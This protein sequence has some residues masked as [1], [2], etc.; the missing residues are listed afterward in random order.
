VEDKPP[1]SIGE[2]RKTSTGL[3]PNLAALL[4][5]ILG[6]VSGVVFYLIEK[7]NKYVRFHAV[8]SILFS[9]AYIVAYVVLSVALAILGAIPVIGLIFRIL[10]GIFFAILGLGSLV[11]WIILMVKAYSGEQYKLPVIGDIAERNA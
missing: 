9:V 10:I 3:E 5:Y 7:E 1:E 4:S 6:I 11:I 8:Q 2:A